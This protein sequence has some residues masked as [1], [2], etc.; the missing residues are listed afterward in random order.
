MSNQ[1]SSLFTS[2]FKGLYN[3]A[4]DALETSFSRTC[5]IHY[6]TTKWTACTSCQTSNVGNRGPNPYITGGQGTHVGIC[7]ACNGERKVPVPNTESVAMI[8]LWEY[9]DFKDL[10]T[11]VKSPA[12]NVQTVCNINK[13]QKIRDASFIVFNTDISSLGDHKF[14]RSGEPTPMGLGSDRYI[15]TNWTKS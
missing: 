9:L 5:T 1:F 7:S 12:G 13:I 2:E 11:A 15:I 14:T 4:I 8:V 6:P 10:A 3:D